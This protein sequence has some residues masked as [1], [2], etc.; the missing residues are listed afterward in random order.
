MWRPESFLNL[1]SGLLAIACSLSAQE[2]NPDKLFDQSCGKCHQSEDSSGPPRPALQKMSPEGIYR[3]ITT[4]RMRTQAKGLS[5]DSKRAIAEF[6]SGRRLNL[7]ELS[8]TQKMSNPCESNPTITALSPETSWNGWGVNVTNSR[9][10]RTS[11]LTAENIPHLKL[12]WA[13]GLPGA[14]KAYGMPTIIAGRVFMGADT[15]MVYS[16]NA[17]SGCVYWSF[18]ADAGVR[19]A[20]SIAMVGG[21]PLAF[22]ADQKTNAYAV[23]ANTGEQVWKVKVGDHPSAIGT[24]APVLYKDRLYVPLASLEEDLG[25]M[26]DYECCTFQ[27]SV[28]ALDAATGRQ[29]WKS[30]VLGTPP[31]RVRKNSRGVQLWAPAGGGVWSAPTIDA[32]RN[33]LY[34]ATGNAYTEP[35]AEG[36]DAIVAMDLTTGKIRWTSQDEAGDA[37]IT[38]C[39]PILGYEKAMPS[40]PAKF[41]ENCPKK[42][43]G[44]GDYGQSPILRKL[45]NGKSIVVAALRN[46][47]VHA[48][49]PDRKGAVVWTAD[50]GSFTLWGG[51]MDDQKLYYGLKNGGVSALNLSTGKVQWSAALKPIREDHPGNDQAVSVIPGFVFVGGEDG[52]VLALSTETGRVIWEYNT[53]QDYQTVNGIAAHGGTIAVGGPTIAGDMLYVGSGFQTVNGG[54]SGNVLL[55][56]QPE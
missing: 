4:G 20:V 21:R 54:L 33:A 36:S 14:T 6:L 29:F 39:G 35:A 27:G 8:A 34:V 32:E 25:A 28:T 7:E 12:K 10:Q 15:G 45:P 52:R 1:M 49:D 55:A 16:I 23:N 46:G 9:F 42:P 40:Q 56:F 30:H 17:Q 44:D 53:I 3:A 38:G 43:G 13:F 37:W 18:L 22:F 24:G 47:Q 51:A 26:E 31:Q 41:Q 2:A 19:T 11:R 5:D 50:L 48:H